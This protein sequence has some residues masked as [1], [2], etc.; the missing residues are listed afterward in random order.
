MQNNF[1]IHILILLWFLTF[2]FIILFCGYIKFDISC[3]SIFLLFCFYL[4]MSFTFFSGGMGKIQ[5]ANAEEF[6][7]IFVNNS[8]RLTEFLEH[9][10]EVK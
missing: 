4:I 7:H 5:K 6:I 8:A 10:I 1:E 2:I 9:M 3:L